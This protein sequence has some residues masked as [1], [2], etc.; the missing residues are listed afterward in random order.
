[1]IFFMA[2]KNI[3]AYLAKVLP[4]EFIRWTN[5][6]LSLFFFFESF[7]IAKTTAVDDALI[8]TCIKDLDV[9]FNVRLQSSFSM[10]YTRFPLEDHTFFLVGDWSSREARFHIKIARESVFKW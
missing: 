6:G 5:S 9:A 3:Q 1:M 10:V 8:T 2:E 4:A 7:Q